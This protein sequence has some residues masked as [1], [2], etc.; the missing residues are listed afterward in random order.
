LSTPKPAEYSVACRVGRLIEARLKWLNGPADVARLQ[1]VM[2]EV[3]AQA[4]PS[5]IICADWREA[6]VFKPE[7]GDAL[8]ELLRR[9][10]REINRS[11]VLLSSADAT[12]GLQIE[13]LF[14][15]AQNPQRRS[16]RAVEP[17][18]AW[19]GEALNPQERQRAAAFLAET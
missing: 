4:G 12:F 19:L 14:R 18:L 8:V 13:R 16:F 7:V 3:F 17:M 1:T 2:L 10:N 6:M 9:G 15:E 5:G 11:G